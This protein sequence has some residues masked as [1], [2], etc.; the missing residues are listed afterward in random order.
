MQNKIYLKIIIN[1]VKPVFRPIIFKVYVPSRILM[2]ITVSLVN[3]KRK[4][5]V[6]AQPTTVKRKRITPYK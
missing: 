1:T 6:L 5:V 3:N 2:A 4:I